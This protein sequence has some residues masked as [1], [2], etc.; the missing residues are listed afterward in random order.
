V[1]I[2]GQEKV[3]AAFAFKSINSIFWCFKTD[4]KRRKVAN[5]YTRASILI[6]SMLEVP[7]S[8]DLEVQEIAL[9]S[10]SI[11]NTI[12]AL[13]QRQLIMIITV[14]VS[15]KTIGMKQ[16]MNQQIM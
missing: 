1:R 15:K 3:N 14:V 5:A 13:I 2:L 8:E 9:N 12:S 11:F 4:F 16:V 7:F 10:R 6:F